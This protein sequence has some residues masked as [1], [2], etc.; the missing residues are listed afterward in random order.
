MYR[1]LDIDKYQKS[2]T[3]YVGRGNNG[4]LIRS[5]MKKRFW[6]QEVYN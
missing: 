1:D 5:L 4:N 6:F 2:L 3:Y